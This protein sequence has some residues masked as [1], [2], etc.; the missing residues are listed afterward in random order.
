MAEIPRERPFAHA[1]DRFGRHYGSLSDSSAAFGLTAKGTLDGVYDHLR[2]KLTHQSGRYRSAVAWAMAEV[3]PPRTSTWIRESFPLKYLAHSRSGELFGVKEFAEKGPREYALQYAS[4]YRYQPTMS[5]ASASDL[6]R[7]LDQPSSW[8]QQV[9]HWDPDTDAVAIRQR[10]GALVQWAQLRGI[11]LFVVRL[12]EHSSLRQRTNQAVERRFR[13]LIDTAF[14]PVPVLNLR[15]LLPDDQFLD[16]EHA[17]WT[18]AWS[19]TTHVIGYMNAL[20]GQRTLW[21]DRRERVAAIKEEWS[22][23][24]CASDP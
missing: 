2:F 13:A 3:I 1:L 22:R 12:P 16:A 5:R 10:S 21:G 8:W 14:A 23:G 4:P 9:F 15:C 6:E 19:N 18:G 20:R 17:V 7:G 24:T 11:E